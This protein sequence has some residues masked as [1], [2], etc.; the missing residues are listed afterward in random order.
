MLNRFLTII[1][2]AF[3][4]GCP[5]TAQ[6]QDEAMAAMVK[7]MTPGPQHA[8]LAKGAGLFAVETT[9]TMPGLPPMTS[10]GEAEARMILGGRFLEVDATGSMMGM[11]TASKVIVGYDNTRE[12]YFAQAM[13]TTSTGT[14]NSTGRPDDEGR[15]VYEGT[16]Y[17]FPTPEGRPFKHVNYWLDDNTQVMDVYDWI[18]EA[19][20][21]VVKQVWHRKVRLF[22]GR[23][24]TG[25]TR[26]PLQEG[27][28]MSATWSV[29]DGVLICR[30]KP[31]GYIRTDASFSNY[32]LELEWRWAPGS[33]GGNSGL[34]VHTS[35][36]NELSGWPRCLEVQLQAGSAGDFWQIGESIVV[37]DLES[38]KNGSRNIKRTGPADVEK[39]LGAWNHMRVRCQGDQVRVWVNGQL[40][41]DG[42]DGSANSG[43]ICL[44]SEGAEIHFR[45]ADLVML[46]G[47]D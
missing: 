26:V 37:D 43:A 27:S 19:W 21:Q 33:K 7:G 25:W 13:S 16:I 44:Q 38:R 15:F 8:E 29:E 12:L 30:G 5:L 42:R 24:L 34:L 20:V 22:D 4:V 10:T 41:N 3:L 18:D 17:E 11:P 28:D 6:T 45:R 35:S 46:S 9:I 32:E 40:V 39:T 31:G 2:V 1:S 23:S 36:P 47:E 14:M